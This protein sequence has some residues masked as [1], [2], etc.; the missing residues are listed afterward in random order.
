[1]QF[2]DQD[3]GHLLPHEFLE[4]EQWRDWKANSERSMARRHLEDACEAEAELA[5]EDAEH[6]G[7]GDVAEQDGPGLIGSQ[8]EYYVGLILEGYVCYLKSSNSTRMQ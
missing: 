5:V 8:V 2:L 7:G 4:D 3:A 1:M 6:G